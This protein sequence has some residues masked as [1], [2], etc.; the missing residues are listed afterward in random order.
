[1]NTFIQ[2]LLNAWK[3]P[4]WRWALVIALLSD[5]V[6]SLAAPM[7]PLQWLVDALTA[8]MLFAALGFR[9]SL[10]SVLA[11]EVVPGLEMFPFWTLVIVALAGIQKETASQIVDVAGNKS[12]EL[13]NEPL[14]RK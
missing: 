9:W 1:M 11:V 8:A 4:R 6:G 14:S 10:L 7:P 13:T 5:A 12:K 3:L 2:S